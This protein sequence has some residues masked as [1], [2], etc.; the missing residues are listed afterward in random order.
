MEFVFCF[1]PLCCF[2]VLTYW[3]KLANSVRYLPFQ[4]LTKRVWS[5]KNS[6]M[7]K[8]KVTKENVVSSEKPAEETKDET[9]QAG[10]YGSE[11]KVE[12]GKYVYS[13][14]TQTGDDRQERSING[15]N[16]P[17]RKVSMQDKFNTAMWF[18]NTSWRQLP[19]NPSEKRF[20]RPTCKVQIPK[21][22]LQSSSFSSR[23][24]ILVAILA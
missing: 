10:G 4:D 6:K 8:S 17:E 1:Q 13:R 2:V 23:I 22:L 11:P 18:F 12:G 9:T 16:P 15:R 24:A 19:E 5:D 14:G 21:R 20:M 7:E 3:T